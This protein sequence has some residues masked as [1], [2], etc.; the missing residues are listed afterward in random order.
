MVSEIFL[1][2]SGT[3]FD[4]GALNTGSRT[5]AQVLMC[6]VSGGVVYPVMVSNSGCLITQEVS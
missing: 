4:Y 3:I 1:S 5:F 2:A 6:G